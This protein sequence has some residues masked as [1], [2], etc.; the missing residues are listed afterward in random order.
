MFNSIHEL[1]NTHTHTHRLKHPF[2]FNLWKKSLIKKKQQPVAHRIKARAL[3]CRSEKDD[4]DENGN[5]GGGSG[6]R[7]LI[8]L[9]RKCK[10][11]NKKVLLKTLKC[12]FIEHPFNKN[13]NIFSIEFN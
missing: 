5:E 4:D 3:P 8:E 12:V 10:S 2:N 7:D 13:I 6:L 11:E 1:S 9:L